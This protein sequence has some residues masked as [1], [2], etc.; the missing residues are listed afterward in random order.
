MPLIVHSLLTGNHSSEQVCYWLCGCR[1]N[2]LLPS[3]ARREGPRCSGMGGR[4]GGGSTTAGSRG[5][6]CRC[7]GHG[8]SRYFG[9]SLLQ[10]HHWGVDASVA[11]QSTDSISNSSYQDSHG[12]SGVGTRS[13]ISSSSSGA[14]ARGWIGNSE[15]GSQGNQDSG[16]VTQFTY[17]RR[18][19]PNAFMKVELPP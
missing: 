19:S 8:R 16:R 11:A 3:S 4:C 18:S 9:S 15:T 1:G 12:G 10:P 5:Q 6:P 17:D 2:C 13:W 7:G 14:A